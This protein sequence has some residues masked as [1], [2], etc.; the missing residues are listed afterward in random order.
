M[1]S[2][3]WR[4]D[5]AWQLL[6]LWAGRSDFGVDDPLFHRDVGFFVF[7]LP[8]YQQVARWLLETLVMA[9]VATVAAY[10]PRAARLRARARA[11]LLVLAA[12]A[13]VVLAWR[14]RLD[15]VR[16]R[17]PARRIGR[18][19]RRRTPTCTSA[20]RRCARPGPACRWPARR[21]ACTPRV[22]RVPPTPLAAVAAV[23]ALAL[24]LAGDVLPR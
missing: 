19:G 2:G 23:A 1:I 11:H 17:A 6:A 8:L 22:R 18:P 5:G 3:Q 4:A 21:C 9:A 24:A 16:A 7:S 14:Y 15:A 20:C 10:A 12:L 13:L